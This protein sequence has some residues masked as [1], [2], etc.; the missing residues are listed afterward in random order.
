MVTNSDENGLFLDIPIT[1]FNPSTIIASVGTIFFQ[2]SHNKINVGISRLDNF[3]TTLGNISTTA[4]VYI[5]FKNDHAGRDLLS[6][7]AMGNMVET[8]FSG[9]VDNSTDISV[10]KSGLAGIS[11]TAFTPG[12]STKL[13]SGA[14]L[15]LGLKSLI[16]SGISA[17]VGLVNRIF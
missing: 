4:H 13:I 5:T 10:L 16:K 6:K 15:K 11:L 3:K 12:L 8:S 1:L 14:Q 7:F 9:T 17:D 2:T